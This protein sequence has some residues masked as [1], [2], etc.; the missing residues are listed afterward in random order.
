[1]L[2]LVDVVT[3][4]SDLSLDD[5][6]WLSGLVDQWG[7]LADLSFADLILW[8]PD[9]D[10]NVFWAA[11]Q[12][13]PMTGP[14]ALEDDVVGDDIVYDPEHLVVESYLS[15][16]ICVSSGNNQHAGI[17]V[18]VRAVPVLR[19]GRCIGV[20]ELHANRMGLR[21]PGAL[22]DTYLAAAELIAQMMRRGDFPL[23]GDPCVPWTSPRVG[24]GSL[25]V[26]PDGTMSFASPNAV[27]AFKRLGW[28]GE[29]LGE[30]F[31]VIIA[32]LKGGR[33]EPV[34]DVPGPLLT[35]RRVRETD[36]ET[37][38]GAARLRT[39]PL[40]DDEGL[41][42]WLVL[43]RDTTD[44]R[45]RERQLV[46]KDATIREIHHRGKNNLQTVAALLRLQT[47][48][49]QSPEAIGALS[50]AQKRVSAIAVVHEMLSQGFDTSVRFDDVADRL[51][52]M[53]RD[54]AATGA[55]VVMQREGSFGS[56]PAEVAT[57]LS[58]V[59]T[60]LVQNALEHGVGQ[61][62]GRIVVCPER[63]GR[64]LVMDVVNDGAPLADDFSSVDAAPSLG[65][66]IVAALVDDLSGTFEI[67]SLPDG[68]GT[69]ARVSF[70]VE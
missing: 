41:E 59:F 63:H 49:T 1:M 18:D 35:Q 47:R 2:T 17:P 16:E 8:V 22:E 55:N 5:T 6:Q 21:A 3:Q 56:V 46:T 50:D 37:R 7:V 24:D 60:E 34:D 69:R 4:H 57:N 66:S 54:V 58:L 53:V 65:L 48:R 10:D 61:R 40:F 45:N 23:A 44:L 33:C 62:D 64:T 36:L 12:C 19:R 52:T 9:V 26:R 30:D 15:H 39:Q 13:R 43:C 42:G 31:T 29:L 25:R 28:P 38:A 20:V 51:M 32:S 14:T 67:S 27:S 70:V 11:A 68:S